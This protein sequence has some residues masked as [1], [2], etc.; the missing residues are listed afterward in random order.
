MER[1]VDMENLNG[2]MEK[3]SKD[4]GIKVKR[5]ASGFGNLQRGTFIKDSGEII[6][7]TAK[8]TM[9]I[10]EDPNIEVFL[11]NF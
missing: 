3:F 5:M 4:S 9:Y 8:V 2:I 10:T 1:E 11:N 7:K 6:G